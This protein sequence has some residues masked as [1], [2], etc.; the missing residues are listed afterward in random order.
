[1]IQEIPRAMYVRRLPVILLS[2][3]PLCLAQT[4]EDHLALKDRMWMA[5]KIYGTILQYFGHWQAV[6]DLKLDDVYRQYLDRIAATDD[7]LNFDLATMEFMGHLRNGHSDFGDAWLNRTNG[8]P[9]GFWLDLIDGKWVVRDSGIQGLDAGQVVTAIEGRPTADFVV[10]K[11]RYI[12]ASDDRIRRAKV[13]FSGFLWPKSFTLTLEGG[14][15]VA[16]DRL[17]PKWKPQPPQ[18]PMPALPEGV[19]YHRIRSFD[20]PK[21]ENAAIEFVKANTAA[22]ILLFDVRGNG[23]GSTPERLLRA[24]MDRPYRDWMQASAMTFGLFATY[25]ELFRTVIP[26]DADARTLGYHEASPSTSSGP[27]S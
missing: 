18:P 11:S 4:A 6:P 15:T 26:K 21:F 5:S 19:V 9:T 14:R 24:L 10:E 20:D 13:F 22:K 8:Q 7:R 2:L 1:M 17:S 16:V 12:A 27:T 23:G 25:G 3:A